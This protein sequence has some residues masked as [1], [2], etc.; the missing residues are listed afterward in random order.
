[1]VELVVSK[2]AQEMVTAL[3]RR[4]EVAVRTVLRL[5]PE[6]TCSRA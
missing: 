1:M 4:L 2:L 6:L 5:V 3:V